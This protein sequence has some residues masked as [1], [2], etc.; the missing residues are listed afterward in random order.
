MPSC[1]CKNNWEESIKVEGGGREGPDTREVR[2]TL[3]GIGLSLLVS[4]RSLGSLTG[5][6]S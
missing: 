5:S 2:D 4:F 3:A 1:P 6:R